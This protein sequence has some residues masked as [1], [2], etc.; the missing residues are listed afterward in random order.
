MNISVHLL[1]K[2]TWKDT[3]IKYS[4]IIISLTY[5]MNC[6]RSDIAYSISKLSKFTNNLGVSHWKVINRM[7]KYLRYTLVPN[8]T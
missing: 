6:I 7:L 8:E 5:V 3:L 1:K 4:E 2:K